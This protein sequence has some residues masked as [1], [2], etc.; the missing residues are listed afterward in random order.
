MAVVLG[1]EVEF[2]ARVD[3]LEELEPGP[4]P[5]EQVTSECAA[6]PIEY[7]L[8]PA[9]CGRRQAATK[10]GLPWA[11]RAISVE[12]RGGLLE[13]NLACCAV[14]FRKYSV[15]PA[16]V[17]GIA[18]HALRVIGCQSGV[19]VGPPWSRPLSALSYSSRKT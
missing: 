12:G 10:R 2:G 8:I 15:L 13:R 11:R 4:A 16:L 1:G 9:G 7:R 5:G 18:S 14:A 17:L 3:W 19:W 6:N